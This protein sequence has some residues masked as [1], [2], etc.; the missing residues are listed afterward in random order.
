MSRLAVHG[1]QLYAVPDRTGLY[2]SRDSGT[3]WTTVAAFK[4][5]YVGAIATRGAVA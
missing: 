3:T 2:V 4:G 1:K 5:K